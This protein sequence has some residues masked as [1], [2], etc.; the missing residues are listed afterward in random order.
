M[1][2]SELKLSK[3]YLSW[4][5]LQLSNFHFIQFSANLILTPSP[6]QMRHL[7]F[8]DYIDNDKY[9]GRLFGLGGGTNQQ[10]GG[11]SDGE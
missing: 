1:P 6:N 4:R 2:H 11:T 7:Y 8:E 5:G 10:N 9:A 3:L